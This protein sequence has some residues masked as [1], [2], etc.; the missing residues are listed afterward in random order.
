MKQF[1]ATQNTPQYG[2]QSLHA[3]FIGKV[4][5]LKGA[6][7]SVKYVDKLIDDFGRRGAS[8]L[9]GNGGWVRVD[10]IKDIPVVKLGDVTLD[11]EESTP[12]EIET[13]LYNFYVKK[14][15]EA[16]FVVQEIVE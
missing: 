6:Q 12:E 13:F 16:K 15:T 1:K 11:I 7:N 10:I 8:I 9:K 5:F 14:Y 3:R 4:F 2:P